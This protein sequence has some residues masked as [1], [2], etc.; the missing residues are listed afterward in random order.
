[1]VGKGK[2]SPSSISAFAPG[3]L[4]LPG[5]GAPFSVTVTVPNFNVEVDSPPLSKSFSS[6]CICS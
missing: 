2:S 5:I 6:V 3:K 1:M 4:Y